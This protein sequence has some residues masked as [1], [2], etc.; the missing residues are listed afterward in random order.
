MS[1]EINEVLPDPKNFNANFVLLEAPG[2]TG[3]TFPSMTLMSTEEF[4][5]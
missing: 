1:S 4:R 2:Y 3:I 5:N